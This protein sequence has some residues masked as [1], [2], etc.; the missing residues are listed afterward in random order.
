M[1]P[2]RCR[3]PG[4]AGPGRRGRGRCGQAGS[5]QQPSSGQGHPQGGRG[6]A[7]HHRDGHVAGGQAQQT[8]LGP[9]GGLD[10]H[11]G[12]G[13]ESAA[14]PDGGEGPDE[15]G[16]RPPFDHQGHDQAEEEGAGHVDGEGGPGEPGGRWDEEPGRSRSGPGC[17]GH[18]RR[19]WRR[20][21]AGA[22]A[23]VGRS[24]VRPRAIAAP[25]GVA[26]RCCS[27]RSHQPVS[28]VRANSIARRTFY[29]SPGSGRQHRGGRVLQALGARPLDGRRPCGEC[30]GEP[31][32]GQ[33]PRA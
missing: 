13:G 31:G 28:A 33:T 14:E 27:G 8:V 29:G 15:A 6:H 17:R 2:A 19:R 30:R 32:V 16:G 1:R 4:T 21:A 25:S 26:C 22:R 11:G 7:G 12:E 3:P 9:L 5:G 24:S 10:G 23:P 20:C 18:R